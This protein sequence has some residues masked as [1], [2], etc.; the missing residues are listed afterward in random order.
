MTST[1][2]RRI[3]GQAQCRGG[4]GDLLRARELLRQPASSGVMVATRSSCWRPGLVRN[5]WSPTSGGGCSGR[6]RG[7]LGAGQALEG[8]PIELLD[9]RELD[10]F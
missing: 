6:E 8:V 7:G 5:G 3:C 10:L 4:A 1:T 9:A 2:S